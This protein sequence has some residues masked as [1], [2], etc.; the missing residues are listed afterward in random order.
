MNSDIEQEIRNVAVAGATCLLGSLV[1]ESL[2]RS[3]RFNVTILNRAPH[4]D[5]PLGTQ[6]IIIDYSDGESLIK[7]IIGILL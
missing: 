1:V 4:G 5:L 7:A 3:G 6:S 2:L